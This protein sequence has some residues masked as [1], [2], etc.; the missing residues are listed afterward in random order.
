MSEALKALALLPDP[1]GEVIE[2][3]TLPNG[4][5]LRQIRVPLGVVGMIYEARPNVTADAAGLCIKTGNAVILRGG[6]M[7]H[8]SNLALTRVLASCGHR[9]RD[10]GRLHPVDRDH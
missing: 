7:A 2:G 9:R 5:E 8:N 4:I 3:H 1:I 6:S 10:A